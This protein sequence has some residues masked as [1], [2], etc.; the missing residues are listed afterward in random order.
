MYFQYDKTTGKKYIF[1]ALN[2]KNLHFSG[3]QET[4]PIFSSALF[5]SDIRLQFL[6]QNAIHDHL[7][8]AFSRNF[9]TW[10]SQFFSEQ[11]CLEIWFFQ[12]GKWKVGNNSIPQLTI[13]AEMK[14]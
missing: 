3:C 4:F 13:E 10:L 2:E 8:T 11:V 9:I 7:S 1:H 5:L 14:R 6:S 12:K